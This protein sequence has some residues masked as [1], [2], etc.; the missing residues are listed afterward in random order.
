MYY[1]KINIFNSIGVDVVV[2]IIHVLCS[3]QFFC[4]ILLTR[5]IGMY[6]QK[7]DGFVQI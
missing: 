7:C 2:D 1:M 5:N 6:S 3:L 4:M